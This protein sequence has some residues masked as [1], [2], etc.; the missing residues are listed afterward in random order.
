MILL[1]KKTVPKKTVD[2]RERKATSDAGRTSREVM[3]RRRRG[4]RGQRRI[5]VGLSIVDAEF[6]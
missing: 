2:G 5:K 3:M 6:E 1:P 4:G